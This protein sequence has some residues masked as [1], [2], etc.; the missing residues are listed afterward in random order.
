[1]IQF[2][3]QMLS[4]RETRRNIWAESLLMTGATISCVQ[5]V[6]C[7]WEKKETSDPD[8]E[9]ITVSVKGG[10]I[11]VFRPAANARA[12]AMVVQAWVV[13]TIVNIQARGRV[14]WIDIKWEGKKIIFA[15]AHRPHSGL[16]E[17]EFGAALERLKVSRQGTQK[18]GCFLGIDANCL[19]GNREAEQKRGQCD[20][21]WARKRERR[22]ITEEDASWNG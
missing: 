15:T 21:L 1:M 19:L 18:N 3:G 14:A 13:S 2:N 10:T 7:N 5:E 12:M 22:W 20:K 17:E 8:L 6:A 11:F 9:W 16:P 4:I